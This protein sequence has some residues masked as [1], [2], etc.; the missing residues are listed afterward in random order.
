MLTRLK[1]TWKCKLWLLLALVSC[2]PEVVNYGYGDYYVEIVTALGNNT[3]LLDRGQTLYDSNQTAKQSFTSGDRV[4]LYFSYGDA[5][6]DPIKVHAASK[7]FSD[8]L[9]RMPEEKIS[10]Q[11]N[12]PVRLE[13]AWTGSRYLNLHLYLEYRSKAHKIALVVDEAQV[14]ESEIHLYLR[15]DTNG[16]T[17]GYPTSIYVSYDLSK[18]LG[19]PQGDRNLLVHLNTTNYGEKTSTFKY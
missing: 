13:S 3:F 11:A 15:H 19:E 5:L 10:Q 18:A 14:E 4:Y 7:I 6:S 2:S 9:K 16:D 1:I 12:A 17:P 8:T